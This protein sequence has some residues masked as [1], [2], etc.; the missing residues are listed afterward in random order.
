MCRYSDALKVDFMCRM[1]PLY[2]QSVAQIS[3]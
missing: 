2:R 1:S 3:A